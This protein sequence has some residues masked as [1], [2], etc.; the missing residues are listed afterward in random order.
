MQLQNAA[1]KVRLP[2]PLTVCTWMCVCV[3]ACDRTLQL[4]AVS[5]EHALRSS[6]KGASS[7]SPR[8]TTASWAPGAPF[9]RAPQYRT[10]ARLAY[11]HAAENL[12]AEAEKERARWEREEA[13]RRLQ[14]EQLLKQRQQER[15]NLLRLLAEPAPAAPPQPAPDTSAAQEPRT[16]VSPRAEHTGVS[17]RPEEADVSPRPGEGEKG[18]AKV[19]LKQLQAQRRQQSYAEVRALASPRALRDLSATAPQGCG[20]GPARRGEA[21]R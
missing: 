17:P 2:P 1:I 18:F 13:Q 7:L 5:A 19:S 16:D 10:S 8:K 9:V 20:G 11:L 21:P 3:C 4:G 14:V 6:R 12:K 15:E